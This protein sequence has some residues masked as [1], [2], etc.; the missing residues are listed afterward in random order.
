MSNNNQR[1]V[2]RY[3]KLGLIVVF[4]LAAVTF[5]D[6]GLG[7]LFALA[8]LASGVSAI[9]RTGSSSP[10]VQPAAPA[11]SAPAPAPVSRPRLIGLNIARSR[12]RD[13]KRG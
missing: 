7:V 5:R 2:T 8:G 9:S 1:E 10:V 6:N 4:S 12:Q 3:H 13:L 11:T